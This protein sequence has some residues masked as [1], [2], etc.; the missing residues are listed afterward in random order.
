MELLAHR[1]RY[2]WNILSRGIRNQKSHLS[3]PSKQKYYQNHFSSTTRIRD[4]LSVFPRR[5]AP[6]RFLRKGRPRGLLFQ[7]PWLGEQRWL[8]RARWRKGRIE[9]AVPLLVT[10]YAGQYVCVC[11]CVHVNRAPASVLVH[12][13]TIAGNRQHTVSLLGRHYERRCYRHDED[14]AVFS[15]KF[16]NNSNMGGGEAFE[17]FSEERRIVFW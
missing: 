16:V 14:I 8:G 13:I 10:R 5:Y 1:Y 11:V 9:A 2:V 15:G 17:L 12:G 7:W 6:R 4:R 3:F